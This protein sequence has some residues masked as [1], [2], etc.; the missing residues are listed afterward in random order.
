MVRDALRWEAAGEVLLGRLDR[1][2]GI[3]RLGSGLFEQGVNAAIQRAH[4]LRLPRRP[5]IRASG[6]RIGDRHQIKQ[7][8]D[9]HVAHG[10]RHLS[11]HP[12]VGDVATGG[13]GWEQQMVAHD[14]GQP[15][16]G[17]R[18]QSG[19]NAEPFG[20]HRSCGRVLLLAT[21]AHVVQPG[22]EQQL[23]AIVELL[24]DSDG[25]GTVLVDVRDGGSFGDSAEQ[26]SVDGVDVEGGDV[27]AGTDRI[28]LRE[29]AIEP[30][31]PW[32]RVECRG[33][34]RV[35]GTSQCRPQNSEVGRRRGLGRDASLF[36]LA[37]PELPARRC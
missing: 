14:V 6:A 36:W 10:V 21:L 26:M 33:F 18:I 2:L 30:G 3:E 1:V 35:S 34:V 16:G 37:T 8:Q 17:S 27:P 9:A 28:P 22:S 19:A 24:G 20:D 13:D 15:L 4:E 25:G 12:R 31:R 32:K 29:Q 5:D 23:V 11:D 7:V